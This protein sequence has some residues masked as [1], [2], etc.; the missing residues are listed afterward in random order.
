M[1]DQLKRRIA[2]EMRNV[3]LGSGEEVVDADHLV[4]VADQAIAQMRAEETGAAGYE[5]SLRKVI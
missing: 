2:E 4:T 5:N 1:A 3:A